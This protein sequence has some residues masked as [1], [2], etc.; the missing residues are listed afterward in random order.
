MS[1]KK[2]LLEVAGAEITK[3]Y[4]DDAIN[5]LSEKAVKV[6]VKEG[7]EIIKKI[8]EDGYIDNVLNTSSEKSA[9]ATGIKTLN[10]YTKKDGKNY[11]F[12]K[13]PSALV[14]TM[15][16][17]I[18]N[19]YEVVENYGSMYQFCDLEGN[20][21]YISDFDTGM[22]LDREIIT[23]YDKEK[24]KYGSVK[25][26]VMSVGV[27]LLET[28]VKKYSVNLGNKNLCKLKKCKFL[29]D[30]ELETLAGDM[31]LKCS[32]EKKKMYQIKRRNKIIA[33]VNELPHMLKEGSTEFYI[34]EYDNIKDEKIITLMTIALFILRD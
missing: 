1:L 6:V 27:P 14:N 18:I 26:Y 28:N 34:I 4:I 19:P 17:F 12:F 23:L 22:M 16:K 20:V 13:V 11:M 30:V 33:K 24:N 15:L 3:K 2:K 7:A 21:K 9:K 32:D 25:E 5:T 10:E 31:H 29:G 8:N